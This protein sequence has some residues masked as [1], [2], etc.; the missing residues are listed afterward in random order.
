MIDEM[1]RKN[2]IVVVKCECGAEIVLL[3]DV[4]AM[5]KAIEIHVDKHLQKRK[6]PKCTA[7]EAERLR[8]DLIAQVLSI[9]SQSKKDG[10]Y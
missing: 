3:T 9:V 5:G 8:D 6:A 7:A 2:G 10:V 1:K 4:K